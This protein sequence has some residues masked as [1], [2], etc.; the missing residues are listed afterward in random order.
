MR[1][2]ALWWWIDRWRKST[3]YTD[4]TLEQQGAYRNLLD[5]ANLRGGAI[6]NDERILAKACGD[7]VR[8]R[9]L[10]AGVL[11]RFELREDGWHNVT[12]DDVIRES[13]RRAEKQSRYRNKKSNA[14][15]NGGG[16][17][18]G[19]PDP[20]PVQVELSKDQESS[21]RVRARAAFAGK[22]LE[23]PKFLDDEFVKRLN[24]Y[25]FDLTGFYLA[26]DKRLAQTGEAWDLRWIRDQFAAESPQPERR[27]VNRD[28]D[29]PISAKEKADA[30][31][32]RRAWGRCQHDPRCQT[33]V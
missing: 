16:N 24:G 33:T 22:V 17:S 28:S 20:S 26:L 5:E 1:F 18:D 19:S 29:R 2:D 14:T 6:P 13:K 21:E 10:R 23:V 11:S 32:L 7:A 25:G 9:H 27:T 8:W 15:S 31:R 12:L 4:M 30:E 3:A